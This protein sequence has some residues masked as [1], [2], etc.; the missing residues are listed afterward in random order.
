MPVHASE[1][2][3]RKGDGMDEGVRD[4]REGAG[5]RRRLTRREMLLVGVTLFSMFFGAGNLIFPPFLGVEAGPLL[6]WALAGFLVSAIGLPVL[7]V[8]AV[9][10]TGGIDALSSRAGRA[11]G[12]AFPVLV[13]L[14][15]GPMLA[16]PRTA[17]TSYSVSFALVAPDGLGPVC[18]LAYTSA[19]FLLAFVLAA[20]PNRL[21]D[22]VGKVSAPVLLALVAFVAVGA[23]VVPPPSATATEAAASYAQAPAVQGFLEGYQTMDVLASLLFGAIVALNVR[24]MGVGREGDVARETCRAGAVMG[25]VEAVV[26]C[27]LAFVGIWASGL[28]PGATN[29]AQLLAA[30]ASS[31]YG[32]AGTL[33]IGAIYVLACLNVCCG[34]VSGCAQ[35]FASRYP[36][37]DYRGWEVAFVLVSLALSNFGLD[38]IITLS[39]P[40]LETLYPV[41]IVLVLL[42]VFHSWADLRPAVWRLSVALTLAASVALVVAGLVWPQGSF[43]DALPLASMGL[44]W[45]PF[46]LVGVVAG[47]LVRPEARPGA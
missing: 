47:A 16:I 7:G 17:S 11:F 20:R 6:P 13:L 29:G 22:F 26:Y 10:N 24:R 5:E 23:L 32:P 4:V 35:E 45:V 3:R 33:V 1:N 18:Q 25:V 34:L 43:L 27:G 41:A 21:T 9:A 12:R 28:V 30:A 2:A 42:G 38:A 14:A 39:V 46:A 15:I 19:F 36:R 40:L 44:G 31:L 8:V 37:L